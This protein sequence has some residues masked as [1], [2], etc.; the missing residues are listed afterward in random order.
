MMALALN[1]LRGLY[2]C[3][4]GGKQKLEEGADALR[5]GCLIVLGAL[6][7][8]VVQITPKLPAFA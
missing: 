4:T 1:K 5:P 7:A 6:H 2:L 3:L 8:F